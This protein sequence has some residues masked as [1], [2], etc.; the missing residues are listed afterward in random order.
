MSN[1]NQDDGIIKKTVNSAPPVIKA[2]AGSIALLMIVAAMSFRI[3][4]F[5]PGPLWEKS[6]ELDI[7]M[8]R[9]QLE[10]KIPESNQ[11]NNA[12]IALDKRL[13]EV[14]KLSHQP[15]EQ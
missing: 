11:Q 15:G 2:I 10:C 1:G 8:R 3:M 13:I 6:I 5:N 9:A 14:E 4:D 7:E 12:I